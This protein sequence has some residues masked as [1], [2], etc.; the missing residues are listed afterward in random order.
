MKVSSYRLGD[1]ISHPFGL[2]QKESIDSYYQQ[3]LG[4]RQTKTKK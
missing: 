4:W 2:N 3:S 1:L